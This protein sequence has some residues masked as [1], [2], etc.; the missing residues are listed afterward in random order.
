MAEI[1][2]W[3][4]RAAEYRKRAAELRVQAAGITHAVAREAM[5]ETAILWERM[6]EYEENDTPKMARST[7][8]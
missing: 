5:L 4:N 7:L 2:P 8:H 1:P 3:K 6:A